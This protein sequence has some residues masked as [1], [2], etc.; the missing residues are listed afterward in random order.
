MTCVVVNGSSIRGADQHLFYRDLIKIQI[1]SM[2][3]M[4]DKEIRGQLI[5]WLVD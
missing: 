3:T 5:D 2:K 1:D 4:R